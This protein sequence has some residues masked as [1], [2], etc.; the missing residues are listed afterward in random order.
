MDLEVIRKGKSTVDCP[1]PLLFVHG[2]W[3]GAWCW[4]EHFLEYFADRGYECLALSLRG[5]GGSP[6]QE[7]LNRARIADFVDDVAQV[8]STLDTPP[9]VIGH[10][11]GG[12]VVQKY[13]VEHSAPGGVLLASVP[14]RGV[15]GVTLGILRSHPWLFVKGNAT[16]DLGKLVA[17]PA[18]AR[19]LFYSPG[20]PEEDVERY[21]AR[22][23]GESYRGF[24][25][26]LALDLPKKG[27]VNVPMLVLGGELDAIFSPADVRRTAGL[28]DTEAKLYPDTAHNLM[29]E[30]RWREVAD[31]I[32]AWLTATLTSAPTSTNDGM[33]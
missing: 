20:M 14:P 29:L 25:D 7:R 17:S 23:G 1:V 24:L 16:L 27:V 26:M 2:A 21:A 28:Y 33:G 4:D 19:E 22:L 10:S 30:P 3:H 31:D 32:A 5:H 11:M 6:G 18:L 9:V 13:L 12:L 8:A 15:I